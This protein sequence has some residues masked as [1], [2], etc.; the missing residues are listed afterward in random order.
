MKITKVII[1]SSGVFTRIPKYLPRN[2]E[3]RN[4]GTSVTLIVNIYKSLKWERKFHIHHCINVSGNE[5]KRQ[6]NI[7]EIE[8]YDR[9]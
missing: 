6:D 9:L 7:P 5:E 8:V 3:D 4:N 1:T 2:W